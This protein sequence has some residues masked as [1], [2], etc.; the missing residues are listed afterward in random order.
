MFRRHVA[1]GHG[2]CRV[3]LVQHVGTEDE[4]HARYDEPPHGKRAQ[5]DDERILETDDVAQSQHGGTRVHLEHQF[6][7]LGQVFAQSHHATGEVLIPPAEGSHDEVVES[8]HQSGYQQRLGLVAALGSAH[9]HLCRGR[10]FGEGILAV[11][12]AHE[13]LAEGDEEQDAD[14]AAQ[15]RREEYLQ[16]RGRH[17]RILGLQDIDGGQREDGTGHHGT[18]AGTYRLNDDVLAQCL[19]A[20]CSRADAHGNDGDGDGGLEHLA[21]L[22]SQIGSSSR[23]EH[24]HQHAPCHRPCVHLRIVALWR[25]H[26]F[27]RFSFVQLPESVFRQLALD[28]KFF[29]VFSFVLIVLYSLFI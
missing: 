8:A 16:E 3:P 24:G 19:V 14:D 13:I 11:H 9:Q 25:Q 29:H 1:H 17:L 10:G 21:H 20:L 7:F 5:T 22:Q 18:R 12:V 2:D 28:F 23:E 27:I 4:S 6:G 26:R 15:Q